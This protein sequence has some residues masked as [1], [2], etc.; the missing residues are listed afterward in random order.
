[1]KKVSEFDLHAYHVIRESVSLFLKEQANKLDSTN[2][3]ILDIAPQEHLGAAEHF[4]KAKIKTADL[5]PDAKA[6]YTIDITKDNSEIIPNDSF[7]VV[8]C[9][10]VLEHTL[11]PFSAIAEIYRILK[12]EGVLLLS[13]PFNFRIHGPLPDCWR[14]TEHGINALLRDFKSINITAVEDE[15][16][17]L[18]PYHYKTIAIK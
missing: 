6:T 3:V 4:F 14:F 7:D 13:T 18:M 11:N 9:T 1:M 17:F 8:V 10:E 12:K 2:I 16:R 5:N 15:A